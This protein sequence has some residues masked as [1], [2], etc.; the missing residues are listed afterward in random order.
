MTVR[1]PLSL[2][3]P[4]GR[5]SQVIA[6][7]VTRSVWWKDG[8]GVSY[9]YVGRAP[10]IGAYEAGLGMDPPTGLRVIQQAA[11]RSCGLRG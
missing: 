7:A 2:T 5:S 3:E 11:G 8:D 6:F 1:K 9:P 4:K 10:D